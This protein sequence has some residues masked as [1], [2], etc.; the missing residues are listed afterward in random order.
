MIRELQATGNKITDE[1]QVQVVIRSLLE[2][3]SD[4]MKMMLIHNEGIKIYNHIS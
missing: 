3:S 1:Q 4:H 2:S